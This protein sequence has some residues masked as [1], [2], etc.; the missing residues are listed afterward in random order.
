MLAPTDN[1]LLDTILLDTILLDLELFLGQPM[2]Q[3]QSTVSGSER[4]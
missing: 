4:G 3:A 2:A 1:P